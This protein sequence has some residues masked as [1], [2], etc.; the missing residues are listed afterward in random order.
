MKIRDS[1]AFVTGVNRV[2]LDVRNPGNV[3]AAARECADV[4]LL[5]NSAAVSSSAGERRRRRHCQRSLGLAEAHRHQVI[6][7]LPQFCA[8]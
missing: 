7:D 3:V 8:A 6:A 1:V 4:N 5:K 2:R